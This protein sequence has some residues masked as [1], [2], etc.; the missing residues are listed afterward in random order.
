M[1][2]PLDSIQTYRRE[3]PLL[4]LTAAKLLHL[5]GSAGENARVDKEL[6]LPRSFGV[7]SRVKTKRA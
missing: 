6:R 3:A 5:S 7:F 1:D 4:T 2:T